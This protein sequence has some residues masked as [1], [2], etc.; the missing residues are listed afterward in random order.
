MQK[1]VLYLKEAIKDSDVEFEWIYGDLF[2]SD[3]KVLT[4]DIFLKLRSKL[5]E[6]LQYT[7]YDETNVTVSHFRH[8]LSQFPWSAPRN[9]NISR[10]AHPIF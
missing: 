5:N 2:Y 7:N 4:K 1:I 3:K 6:S 9:P 8:L 10:F